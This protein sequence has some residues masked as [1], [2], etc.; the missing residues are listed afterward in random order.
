MDQSIKEIE[1]T[2]QDLGV[3]LSNE[4]DGLLKIN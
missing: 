4:S 3:D 2:R 1:Q